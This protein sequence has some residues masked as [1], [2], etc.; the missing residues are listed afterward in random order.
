MSDS[1]KSNT[2]DKKIYLLTYYTESHDTGIIGYWTKPLTQEEQHS[3][4]AKT[5]PDDYN[6]N[7]ECYIT[8]QQKELSEREAPEPMSR[9]EW[10]TPI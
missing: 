2:A 4:F 7:G 1:V 5:M 9:E 10:S 8:W 3:V 6:V